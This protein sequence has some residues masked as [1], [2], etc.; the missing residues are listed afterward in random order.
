MAQP[1]YTVASMF[2][3]VWGIKFDNF[4]PDLQNPSAPQLLKKAGKFGSP[5]Y[6]KDGTGREYYLPVKITYP[7]ETGSAS[8]SVAD[9]GGGISITS[10]A[11]VGRLVEWWLPYPVVSVTP[12]KVY[13]DTP[14]THN[15]PVTEFIGTGFTVIEIKGL[16]INQKN[17]FPEDDY[18]K[19]MELWQ[20]KKPVYIRNPVTDIALLQSPYGPGSDEVTIRNLRFP[21]ARGVKHVRPY[22]L[23]LY[24]NNPFNLVQI[25]KK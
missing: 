4:D 3:K 17:E 1:G 10:A 19:L 14:L 13:K 15:P 6:R 7:D 2:E 12:G 11:P 21:D 22:E 8:G 23:T 16:L 9:A 24:S 25:V 5:F 20:V 18:A